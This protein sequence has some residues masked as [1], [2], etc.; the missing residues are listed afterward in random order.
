M[1][2][3]AIMAAGMAELSSKIEGGQSARDAVADMYKTN[4]GVI[5]TGNGYSAEWPAEAA[6]RGLANLKTTPEAIKTWASDKNIKL[7]ESMGIFTPDETKARAETMYEAYNTT[8]SIEAQTVTEMI[9]TGILPACAKD[10]SVF[11]DAP[12]L[13][14]D[15]AKL[16]GSIKTE[17]DKLQQL[18]KDVP[19]DMVKEAEYLCNTVKPQMNAVRALVDEA[20][21]LLQAGL[22]PYPTY[23]AMLYHHHH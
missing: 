22:Y 9:N 11:K 8:L 3:N 13:A 1:I 7:F 5:F 10:L 2:C 21:G 17:N 19:H 12:A 16:Y 18:V 14:G 15:R 4:R 23:E 6:K 20:E